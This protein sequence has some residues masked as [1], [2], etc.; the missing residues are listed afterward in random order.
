MTRRSTGLR[1]TERTTRARLTAAGRATG[2]AV[3]RRYDPTIAGATA[4]L[5]T[6]RPATGF[7]DREC[8]ARDGIRTGRPVA[9][10]AGCRSCS[11]SSP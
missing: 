3:M 10:M 2:V 1:S 11:S 4:S 6:Q 8:T 5:T 9:R 7:I